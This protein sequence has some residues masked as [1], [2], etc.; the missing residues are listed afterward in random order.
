MA[1]NKVT[2]VTVTVTFER[3]YTESVNER[4]MI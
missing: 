2:K 1:K 3:D 4:T